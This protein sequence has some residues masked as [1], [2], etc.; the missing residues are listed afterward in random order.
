M[1]NVHISFSVWIYRIEFIITA[2]KRTD[3][4]EDASLKPQS[5]IKICVDLPEEMDFSHRSIKVGSHRTRAYSV[6][7]AYSRQS[8]Y[9]KNVHLSFFL[10]GYIE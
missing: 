6:A 5:Y 2:I 9:K 7:R 10:F 1:K 8:K 3:R 4:E